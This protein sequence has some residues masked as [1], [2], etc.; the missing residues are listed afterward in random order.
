MK[1]YRIAIFVSG[2]GSNAEA[3]MDYFKAHDQISVELLLSNNPSAFALERAKK[4]NVT[5]KV[6]SRQELQSGEVA[7]LL[8]DSQ[9]THLVLAG[10]LWMIP[11]NL[12]DIFSDRIINIH[13]SLLPK[14]GGKGMFGIK[15]HEAVKMAGELETGLTIHLVNEISPTNSAEDISKKVLQLEH[16][17]YPKV[18]EQWILKS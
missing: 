5:S 9:I 10:F 18:I 4:F 11:K 13:P 17:H 7:S 2:S 6:F 8:K 15:V 16:I 12:T 1:K 14:F 3:V